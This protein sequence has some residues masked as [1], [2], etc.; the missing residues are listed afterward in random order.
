[1][2]DGTLCKS[3]A[4]SLSKELGVGKD[5]VGV[6]E[7]AGMLSVAVSVSTLDGVSGG[8]GFAVA[9]G[10]DSALSVPRGVIEVSGVHD[11]RTIKI[12]PLHTVIFM[13]AFFLTALS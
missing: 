10:S 12:R 8:S 4:A 5:I 13:L 7:L 3:P 1:M 11:T 6:G 9:T 2:S